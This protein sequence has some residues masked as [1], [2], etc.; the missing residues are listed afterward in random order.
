MCRAWDSMLPPRTKS[1]RRSPTCS[2]TVT[3]KASSMA[4]EATTL[5]TPEQMAQMRQA[6]SGISAQWT[7]LRKLSKKRSPS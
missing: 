4:C 2:V 3:P 5:C 6:T 1:R 7:R